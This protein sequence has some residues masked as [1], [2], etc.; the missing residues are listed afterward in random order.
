M[1]PEVALA[2]AGGDEEREL[3]W[4]LEERPHEFVPLGFEAGGAFGPATRDLLREVA[5]VAGAQT[6]TDLY[7]RSA[8]VWGEQWQ[9]RLSL[10][11]ARGQA[12][13]VLGAI[14]A[15]RNNAAGALGRKASPEFSET[16]CQPCVSL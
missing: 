15:A 11:L 10:V 13:L 7:H 16:E 8:M 1:S 4:V 14:A 12:T 2:W 6:S 3:D 9:Q 5:R